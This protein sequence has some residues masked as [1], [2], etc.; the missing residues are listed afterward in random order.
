MRD[1]LGE[2]NLEKLSDAHPHVRIE[3][4]YDRDEFAELVKQADAA[5]VQTAFRFPPE[6]L[7][8][9][10]R[11]RWIQVTAAGV[12]QAW[13]PEL[14]SAEQVVI[15]SSKGPLGSLLA[16]RTVML[17]LALSRDIR[18]Y[19]KSQAD[20]F[21]SRQDYV[22]PFMS[23]LMGK[24]IAILGVGSFGGNLARICKVGFGM[25]ILGMARTSSGNP[26]VDRYF[27][28]SE[29]NAA[30]ADADVVALCLPITSATDKIIDAVAL[31]A[32]KPTAYLINGARGTLV[33]EEALIDALENGS[34]AGA[35]LDSTTVEPLPEDSPLWA[36]PNVIITPHVGP[37]TDELGKSLVDF[38][39]ENI[40]RFAEN[41][42]LLDTVDRHSEY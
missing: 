29:L 39:C 28:R 12:N 2:Q 5:I 36:M 42:P 23:Q 24:T 9:E 6:A 3:R 35:G 31:A 18:G 19:M 14:I 34:I 32:M 33:D 25:K 13:T 1:L 4:T 26:H 11:L 41:E 10:S 37:G 30:L 17:M 27:Q 22:I 16:E 8:P 7:N 15:T 20:R 21:W 38:W 40:R